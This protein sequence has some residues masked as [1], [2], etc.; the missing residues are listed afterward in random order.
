M[1]KV[2]GGSTGPKLGQGRR[3]DQCSNPRPQA[4]EEDN[5]NHR[6]H[7]RGIGHEEIV[8]RA[9]YCANTEK[10]AAGSNGTIARTGSRSPGTSRRSQ[11]TYSKEPGIVCGID[12]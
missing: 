4:K 3:K 7:Q 9:N 11:G 2:R 8:G 6:M 10:R 1:D 5:V 12:Q